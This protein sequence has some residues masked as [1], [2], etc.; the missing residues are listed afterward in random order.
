ML[1]LPRGPILGPTRIPGM[2]ERADASTSANSDASAAANSSSDID[3]AA[4]LTLDVEVDEPGTED[5]GTQ[6]SDYRFDPLFIESDGIPREPGTA[7]RG[8]I[9][10]QIKQANDCVP[11]SQE[12]SEG[13]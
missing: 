4:T 2:G 7:T 3:A 13:D 11:V 5:P 10:E 9:E 6:V 1:T 8:A 12:N